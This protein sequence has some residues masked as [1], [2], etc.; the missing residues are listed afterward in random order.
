MGRFTKWIGREELYKKLNKLQPNA[1]R[2]LAK[3][4]LEAAQNLAS[5][6]RPRA[7]RGKTG[8]YAASIEGDYLRY[9]KAA[10]RVG[11][12]RADTGANADPNATGIFAEYIWRFLEFGTVKMSAQPHI[13]PVYRASKKR[14]RL[15]LNK[16]V[17]NAL[18][19]A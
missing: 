13:F 10:T 4:Q 5:D 9:R 2:E 12:G 3:V 15:G 6:I 19:K 7:P 18:R 11:K 1:V 8:E 17:R 14:I 16:A